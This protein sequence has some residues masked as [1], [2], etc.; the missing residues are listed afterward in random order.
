MLRDL[1][2]QDFG[3]DLPL[4]AGSGRTATDPIEI[5]TDSLYLATEAQD[6]IAA[7]LFGAA[8]HQWRL[9]AKQLD[10]V[11]PRV[12]CCRY[13]IRFLDGER[14]VAEQRELY[15]DLTRLGLE[16]GRTTPACGLSLGE[17]HGFGLPAQFGWL[18]F[19]RLV[20][21]EAP[22]RG[23][24]LHYRARQTEVTLDIYPVPA[25]DDD[26]REAGLQR[27]LE[28]ALARVAAE[29]PGLQVVSEN[30]A[31]NLR[32]ASFDAGQRFSALAL[33]SW[34]DHYCRVRLTLTEAAIGLD[35]QCLMDSL[36]AMLGYF[37]PAP[38]SRQRQDASTAAAVP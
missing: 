11:R 24:T 10:P 18:H 1:L 28:A 26:E 7:C 4:G 27:E 22:G 20:R 36:S 34:H 19:E 30:K 5:A 8:G 31:A 23:L 38:G 13:E 25:G 3:L 9:L 14:P 37:N 32:Y 29:H 15:F 33:T 2:L 35:F 6:S 21:H 17:E 12:E 16:S